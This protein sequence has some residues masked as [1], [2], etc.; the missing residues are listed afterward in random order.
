MEESL[1]LKHS[2]TGGGPAN[3]IRAYYAVAR[4]EMWLVSLGRGT[5]A[6]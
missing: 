4:E 5:T 1:A 2:M 3:Q 6:R